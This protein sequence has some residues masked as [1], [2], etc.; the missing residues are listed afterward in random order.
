[1]VDL[2]NVG[3]IV[4]AGP[5]LPRTHAR[6]ASAAGFVLAGGSAVAAEPKRQ[7]GFGLPSAVQTLRSR[8]ARRSR[9]AQRLSPDLGSARETRAGGPGRSVGSVRPRSKFRHAAGLVVTE[10]SHERSLA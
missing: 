3:M 1:M 10:V 9:H 7:H 8:G 6:L 4:M 5:H 2:S